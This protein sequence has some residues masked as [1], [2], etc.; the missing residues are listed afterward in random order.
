MGGLACGVEARVPDCLKPEFYDMWFSLDGGWSTV[1]EFDVA[2]ADLG[3]TLNWLYRTWGV[4]VG[5]G[6]R[7]GTTDYLRSLYARAGWSPILGDWRIIGG[8]YIGETWYRPDPDDG[9]REELVEIGGYLEVVVPLMDGLRMH[10]RFCGGALKSSVRDWMP[11]WRLD[12]GV[13][14]FI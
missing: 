8:G 1:E 3:A 5:W 14:F 13:C 12:A 4:H 7:G 6:Y 11:V 10:W 2:E 9:F